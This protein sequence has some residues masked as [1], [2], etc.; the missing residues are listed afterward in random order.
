MIEQGA[1]L[2]GTSLVFVF[3]N[4]PDKSMAIPGIVVILRAPGATVRALWQT[5][6]GHIPLMGHPGLL[7]IGAAFVLNVVSDFRVVWDLGKDRLII[8]DML[9][10]GAIVIQILIWGLLPLAFFLVRG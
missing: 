6:R 10:V 4:K 7:G 3:L 9:G 2:V 1:F 5:L 8:A